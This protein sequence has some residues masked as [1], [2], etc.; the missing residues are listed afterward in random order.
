M[1]MTTTMAR[2]MDIVKAIMMMMTM[3]T[4]NTDMVDMADMAEVMDMV[5]DMEKDTDGTEGM[6]MEKTIKDMGTKT[7]AVA[8]ES[9][10]D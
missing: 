8:M 2:D 4:K 7:T 10:D 1:M 5:T 9:N 3:I 6:V